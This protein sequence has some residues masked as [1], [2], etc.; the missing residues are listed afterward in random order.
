MTAVR[1]VVSGTFGLNLYRDAGFHLN[2]DGAASF[3]EQLIPALQ[4]AA[5]SRPDVVSGNAAGL[6]TERQLHDEDILAERALR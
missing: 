4:R 1:P 6:R 3:T 5:G 2:P